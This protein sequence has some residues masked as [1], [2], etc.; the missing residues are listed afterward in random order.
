MIPLRVSLEG[1]LSYKERQTIDFVDSSLW[2]L[3]GP[4]GVGKSAIFDAITF[5]L[6]NRHRAGSARGMKE[7]I[8]HHCDKLIVEFDFLVDGTAYRIRRT[9]EKRRTARPTREAFA[10]DL[11]NRQNLESARVTPIPGTDDEDGLEEWVQRTIG[12]KYP[13]FTSS[14]LLL[15]GESE[16]LLHAEPR[17]RYFILAE[18]IDLSRYQRLHK[19]AEEECKKYKASVDSFMEQLRSEVARPVSDE[20]IAATISE[21]DRKNEEYEQVQE[22]IGRLTR[23]VGQAKQWESSIA[24]LEKHRGNL[25][26]LQ[27]LLERRNEIEEKFAELQDLQQ[28]LPFARQIVAQRKLIVA[29]AERIMSLES[30]DQWLATSL[31]EAARKKE[32]ADHDVTQLVQALD[33]LCKDQLQYSQRLAELAPL[34]TTLEQIERYQ[35][36]VTSLEMQLAQYSPDL[37]QCLTEAEQHANELVEKAQA[38]PWLRSFAQAR[39]GVANSLKCEQEAQTQLDA[40]YTKLQGLEDQRNSLDTELGLACGEERRLLQE[41]TETN[42]SYKEAVKRLENF[43]QTA[44]KRVCDLCGQPITSEHAQDEKVRLNTK[45]QV[46]YHAFDELQKQHEEAAKHQGDRGQALSEVAGRIETLTREYNQRESERR[47]AGSQVRQHAAHLRSAFGNLTDPFKQRIAAVVPVEDTGWLETS[48]P[49]DADLESLQLEVAGKNAHESYLQEL[50]KECVKRQK[51]EGEKTFTCQQIEQLSA[52]TN[53]EAARDARDERQTI[54]H[55]FETIEAG[56]KQRLQEQGEAKKLAQQANQTHDDLYKKSRQCITDLA[57]AR[58]THEE[59][60]HTVGIL[61]DGLSASWQKRIAVLDDDGVQGLEQRRTFL[62]SYESSYEQLTRAGEWKTMHE[63][64]IGELEQEIASYPQG[65]CRPAAEIEQELNDAE[66]RQK[67]VDNERSEISKHR[68][69]LEKQ[70]EYRRGLEEQRREA[71]RQ[72]HLYKLLSD[73]LGRGG[74]QLHL[75]GQ[76]ETV[77]VELANR[78]LNG[79]SHGRNRLELRRDS[80]A[81]GAQMEKALDLVAYDYDTSQN[82]IPIN[83]VSGSQRFRIAVSL[84]LAIGRYMGQE[85]RRIESVIIDEGFGSLDKTGRDDMIQELT[86]LGQQLKRIILVSHQDEFANAFPHRYSFKLVDKASYV[87][88]VDDE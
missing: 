51:L 59:K 32:E 67:Q 25:Q 27:A 81:S 50:R 65:A 8:N 19:R 33:D 61:M 14:V 6:Y 41:K 23:L 74:L 56:I 44:E 73:L 79:L 17:E 70:R 76:A 83:L 18:L 68:V 86:S 77:I 62:A 75:L 24:Q 82:A 87:S 43:E 34:V 58:A 47:Q 64:Q 9:C 49:M 20:E 2:M 15:Q 3:W 42:Q 69:G 53:I 48:Y 7:L 35:E 5:A 72:Y 31:Q 26:S 46:A 4:N 52:S 29:E 60:K 54:Q 30:K 80:D 13:A 22:E 66:D 45:V 21:L 57:S 36:Q 11:D 88:L 12:L 71:Q 78:T 40:L 84:A 1:F 85:A 10:L 37:A 39:I 63:R 28:A 38:L 16:K 55:E